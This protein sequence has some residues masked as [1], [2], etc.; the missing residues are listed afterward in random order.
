[1]NVPWLTGDRAASI[2]RQLKQTHPDWPLT[3]YYRNPEADSYFNDVVKPDK[4]VHGVFEDSATL[5]ALA[6]SHDLVINTGSSFDPTLSRALV[7]G[8]KHRKGIEKGTL[9]H[10][11][12]SGNFIDGAVDGK[13]NP[14]SKVWNVRCGCDPFLRIL[15]SIWDDD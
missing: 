9:V 13:F 2:S 7:D 8:L 11:S 4:I 10:I 15:K 3:V 14:K 5:Q 12:G 1:M 6:A